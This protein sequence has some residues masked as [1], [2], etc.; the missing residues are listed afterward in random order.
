[1]NAL[2]VSALAA[3]RRGFFLIPKFKKLLLLS[4]AFLSDYPSSFLHPMTTYASE[5]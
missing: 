1:M 4:L 2:I 3:A 5:S